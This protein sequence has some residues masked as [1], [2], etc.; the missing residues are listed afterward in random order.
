MKGSGW[1]LAIG[2][3]TGF[4]LVSAPISRPLWPQF[5]GIVHSSRDVMAIWFA[6]GGSLAIGAL[7][8]RVSPAITWLVGA[9][10]LSGIAYGFQGLSMMNLQ[11]LL[12]GVGLL[13]V[14][15]LAWPEHKGTILWALTVAVA[16]H[17]AIS[18]S[19]YFVEDFGWPAPAGLVFRDPFFM[20]A[21]VVHEVEGLASHYSLY[22]GLLAVAMPLLYLRI[23]WPV[24]G[25]TFGVSF[26]QESIP[27]ISQPGGA[28]SANIASVVPP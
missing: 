19:Q 18:L 17:V 15:T 16:V 12:W 27:M 11:S 7:A 14:L 21:R 4:L 25:C 26:S 22:A 13:V 9:Y 1:K 2:V 8:W 5:A 20:T 24:W 23:G 3:G 6:V 10:V 28:S